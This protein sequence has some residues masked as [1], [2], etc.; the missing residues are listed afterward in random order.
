MSDAVSLGDRGDGGWG[1]SRIGA[2]VNMT[3]DPH[4]YCVPGTVLATLQVLRTLSYWKPE[5]VHTATASSSFLR[6]GAFLLNHL[7]FVFFTAARETF[8]KLKLGHITCLKGS[9]LF[10]QIQIPHCG[11]KGPTIQPVSASSP[12]LL[13]LSL[14]FIV[15]QPHKSAL[16]P[17]PSHL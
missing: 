14:L 16:T 10:L 11:P 13:P 17:P 5:V 9:G 2:S 3:L 4:S 7:P 12:H 15:F 8:E 1:G 6:K